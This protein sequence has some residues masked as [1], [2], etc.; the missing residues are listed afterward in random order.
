MGDIGA[1]LC[2]EEHETEEEEI[3]F[4]S[5]I[6][7]QDQWMNDVPDGLQPCVRKLVQAL[8]SR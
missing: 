7:E 3:S 4:F 5:I 1:G 2:I 8:R 6:E